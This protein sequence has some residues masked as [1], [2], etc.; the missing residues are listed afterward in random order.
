MKS[1]KYKKSYFFTKRRQPKYASLSKF[2]SGSVPLAHS[3]FAETYK[4]TIC[5]TQT[6]FTTK[7][8]E[9]YICDCKW[10]QLQMENIKLIRF[11]KSRKESFTIYCFKQWSVK[12]SKVFPHPPTFSSLNFEPSQDV[13][14]FRN[15]WS[16]PTPS[17]IPP[18]PSQ[19]Q[20]FERNL[21]FGVDYSNRFCLYNPNYHHQLNI[22]K[23]VW[24]SVSI[25]T[26][27]ALPLD[28]QICWTGASK[29]DNQVVARWW[30]RCQME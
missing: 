23:G 17:S 10:L 24:G 25:R 15:W 6:D 30:I 28:K 29:K 5:M 19:Y 20:D 26:T 27:W 2:T 1:E 12:W 8:H 3:L 7:Q 22:K 21:L 16:S 11:K 4:C 18:T 14:Q 13:E 9:L